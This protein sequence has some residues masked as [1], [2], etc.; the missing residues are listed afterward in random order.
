MLEQAFDLFGIEPDVDLDVMRR[1][2]SVVGIAATTM[3][4]FEAWLEQQSLGAVVVQGDTTSALATAQVA[5]HHHLPICHVEAGLRTFDVSQP[6]P[7]EMNRILLS[8]LATIHCAPTETSR[9]NLL[10]EGIAP[11]SVNITGNTVVDALNLIRSQLADSPPSVPGLP[12]DLELGQASMVLITGHRRENLGA[13][14]ANVCEAIR[15]LAQSFPDT[16]FVYPVHLNP[17]V[18]ETVFPLLGNVPNVFLIPPVDYR[19]LLH[20]MSNSQLI[21]SDSGG[22]Q[23]EVPSFGRTVLVTRAVTERPEGVTAGNSVIVGCDVNRIIS[24]A[25]SRLAG[26]A[27]AGQFPDVTNPY[28]DG[29]AAPRVVDLLVRLVS[30]GE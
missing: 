4:R 9:D 21:I 24:E 5:F 13:R 27:P 3:T 30:R 23:E 12:A 20:L 18:G 16:A 14:L 7:E 15:G 19:Q 17:A 29:H 1:G 8:R 10:R 26:P 11:E 22:I 25:H 2:Q 28:G 6:F